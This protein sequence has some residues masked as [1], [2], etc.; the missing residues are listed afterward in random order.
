MAIS[1]STDPSWRLAR[2]C[3]KTF[4][5]NTIIAIQSSYLHLNEMARWLIITG[6]VLLTIGAILH[7]APGLLNWFGKLPGDIDMESE[8]GRIFIP[9]TSMIIVSI[10]ISVILSVLANIF[11]R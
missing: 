8:N 7:F 1:Q 10:F 3:N 4:A 11:K 2:K 5:Q 6:S 9:I